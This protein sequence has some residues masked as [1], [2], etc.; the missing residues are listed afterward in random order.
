M[1]H[2]PTALAA[3]LSCAH[4]TQ[5]ERQRRAGTLH[6]EFR[7]D[8]RLKGLQERGLQHELAYVGSLKERGRTIHDLTGQRDPAVTAA[9]MRAGH[10]VIVQAPLGGGGF[11]GIADVLLRVE[12]PSHLGAW[13]YE[14]VDTKLA[15][16]TRASTILQLVT[17][18]E[19]MM[20]ALGHVPERFHVV[21]P[22]GEESYRTADF[23]AYFR[24]VRSGLK[25]ASVAEPPPATYPDPVEH[26]DICKYWLH[27]DERRRTDDHPSL[28]AGIGQRHVR[29]F[30]AQELPTMA[31]I[32]Y[33]NGTLAT[34]P[35]R[36]RAETYAGLGQ[37]ARLQVAA[38]DLEIPP[39]ERLDAAPGQGFARLPEPSPGDIFLDFEG[40]PFAGENGL[41][42]L[43]GW[44]VRNIGPPTVG[45]I[46]P[47]GA[48]GAELHQIW[49]LN[50]RE[51]KVALERFI[52]FAI[53]RWER[54]P[55]LH[56][57]HF[58]AYEP[59]T[60][61]RLCAR[62]ET[63]G[64][65]LDRLLRAERFID[66]HRVVR[67][68][69][70]I[71]IERY[72]LKELEPLHRFPREQDLREAGIARRDVE[73]ALEMGDRAALTH[74][75]REMVERYNAEDCYS[76]EALRT[77]LEARRAEAIAA[78]M[79]IERPTVKEAAP[80]EGVNDRDL[81]IQALKAALTA[82]LPENDKDWSDEHKAIALL[83]SMLGYYRQEEK[84]AWWEH[85]RLRD[86]P[87][88]EHLEEREMVAGLEFAG[89]QAKT[90]KQ[91][92]AR[93]AYRFPP[94]ECAIKA[95]DTLFFVAAEDPAG[96]DSVGTS[97]K[98]EE[99]DTTVGT[100]LVSGG[101]VPEDAHPTVLFADPKGPSPAA[102]EA[103]LLAFADHVRDHGFAREGP[104]AAASAL[105]LR[106][107]PTPAAAHP[108]D[109][110]APGEAVLAAA[111]R[112][113][114]VLDGEVLPIQGPPGAGKTFTGG[115]VILDLVRAGLRV[116]VTAVSHKVI[117]NLLCKVRDVAKESNA[118][119][120]LVHK[121]K[122]DE[123][124]PDGIEYL[125]DADAVLATLD[126]GAVV[127]GTVFL[128]AG[129][130]CVDQLDVLVI[131]EAGQMALTNALAA[132]RA[133]KS[134]LLLGDPQQLEQ[135]QRGAHP[136]G[137]DVAAL[138]HLVGKK[139]QT[140]APDRGLFLYVTY[141]LHPKVCEFTSELYYESRL[142][143]AH[144]TE[145]QRVEGPTPFAGAGLFLVDVPHEGNQA[146]APEEVEAVARV[147]QSLLK[148]KVTWTD[149]R[150][151]TLALAPKDILVVAPYN[152]QVSALKARLAP[153]GVDCVG[154]VDRF[155]G[156]EAPVVIYSCTSSSP[157]DAPRGMAFLYDPHR[158]NVATSRAQGV[159]IVVASP[160][161]FEPACRTPEQMRW[162]NGLCRY[163]EMA[164]LVPLPS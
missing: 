105:L 142:K 116:G 65:A 137:A 112:L 84:N 161:L 108:D 68:A 18:C 51:E 56:I 134:V 9:A 77:W 49:A 133:A 150:G 19:L 147:V 138:V 90:G 32:A 47:S 69:M 89:L 95:G 125:N 26:C 96:L 152:A 93:R 40:D 31:A 70:R 67:E 149:D 15:R 34:R 57:Y 131:D 157:A 52:D 27:C 164:T 1:P 158:F 29:E 92:V 94:Q 8:P 107:T 98:V 101:K 124:A 42:Y 66:L 3:H 163:R 111:R 63:R 6:V 114:L 5:L 156:Q 20:E 160:A 139:R 13:S 136:D 118:A 33:A 36:G 60:L 37:Q 53:E 126:A 130:R 46:A 38:R 28:I 54:Y 140:V 81:R 135:P 87:A 103:S 128:W 72:G 145:R 154:T 73:L 80:P 119:I 58:G 121:E 17:Y 45:A 143:S 71:G 155:Q 123:P 141:R 78:G 76:T 159:V 113:S 43:T 55:G 39:L 74:D 25:A 23:G 88:D 11:F 153:L 110:R 16:E 59:S 64:E 127:G 115:H 35:K 62:H 44:H 129:D 79:A 162:A 75:L 120:R 86:L 4:V 91:R 22:L 30:Q 144:G 12:A 102:L 82:Q 117:D 2:S 21:T 132:S 24:F 83:A 106:R 48:T 85:F 146:V 122:D 151:K 50:P 41:E 109:L 7:A 104:F 148:P 14:P 99:I 97:F 100:L 10:G 61:K